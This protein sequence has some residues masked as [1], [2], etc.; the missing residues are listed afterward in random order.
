MILQ[1]SARNLDIERLNA[2]DL[3]YNYDLA[4]LAALRRRLAAAIHSYKGAHAQYEE[5][6]GWWGTG[7]DLSWWGVPN[8]PDQEGSRGLWASTHVRFRTALAGLSWIAS[9]GDAFGWNED[10]DA[11]Q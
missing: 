2:D 11:L 8:P 3:E 4:G 10:C 9:T 5:V 1:V 7:D 6:R